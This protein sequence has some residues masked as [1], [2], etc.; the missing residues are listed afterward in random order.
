MSQQVQYEEELLFAEQ[1]ADDNKVILFNDEVNTF[2]FVIQSLIEVCEHDQIQAEQATMI[3]H[4]NGKC[5][6]KHGEK[7]KLKPICTELLRR[8]LTAEIQ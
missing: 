7:D 8:G 4:Y 2:D 1:T 6:V 3:V 5:D